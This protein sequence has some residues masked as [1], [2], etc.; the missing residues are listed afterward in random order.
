MVKKVSDPLN[1]LRV[2]A[3][4]CVF[5]LHGR[6]YVT[7]YGNTSSTFVFLSSLPAWA[8]VWIFLFLSGY[9]ISLGYEKG[10]YA[11]LNVKGGLKGAAKDLLKFYYGRF[12]KLA[13]LYYG[14]CFLLDLLS[15]RTLLIGN[16]K[17]L[18][19]VLTFTCNG[20]GAL[21][22]IGHLWYVSTAMQ[23]YLI[24]PFVRLGIDKL[25]TTQRRVFA[26]FG[27]AFLGL[28]LRNLLHMLGIDW[29]TWIYTFAPMNFD[30]VICGMLAATIISDRSICFRKAGG[31]IF[32]SILFAVL[33][34]YNCY[35]YTYEASLGL[36]IYRYILPTGYIMGCFAV[37]A[38]FHDPD[39]RTEKVTGK[40]LWKYP[41]RFFDWFSPYTYCFYVVHIYVF[42][43]LQKTLFSVEAIT[44]SSFAV[45]YSVFFVL[46]FA[47]ATM[48]S[49]IA[50]NL[51]G[52]RTAA[53]KKQSQMVTG[54]GV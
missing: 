19:N 44:A 40:M 5:F 26:F 8:G 53:K 42:R 39:V 33:I 13:P 21:S 41:L 25:R 10:R 54:K 32:A 14:Y 49:V 16:W 38:A 29:Y 6:S 24:M 1:I 50:T 22:G 18:L 20:N 35:I 51:M 34:I 37:L 2:I 3:T 52:Y 30:F 9:L 43:Y 11:R 45:R 27:T 4:M 46:A 17:L 15:D 36:F 48:V 47:I 28:G 7:K 31:K 23:L 12:L